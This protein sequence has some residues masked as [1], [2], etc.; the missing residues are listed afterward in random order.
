[1]LH[2][3]TNNKQIMSIFNIDPLSSPEK[4]SSNFFTSITTFVGRIIGSGS[5][6]SSSELEKAKTIEQI[7][8]IVEEIAYQALVDAV[9]E[10]NITSDRITAAES[11]ILLLRI[12]QAAHREMYKKDGYIAK[13]A[14]LLDPSQVKHV[15]DNVGKIVHDRDTKL[16]NARYYSLSELL[17][18]LDDH[19]TMVKTILL[20]SWFKCSC[21][22]DEKHHH[23]DR[24]KGNIQFYEQM[25]KQLTYDIKKHLIE[26]KE[27]W[28]RFFPGVRQAETDKASTAFTTTIE[29]RQYFTSKV[30]KKG[31]EFSSALKTYSATKKTLDTP[32]ASML[33][34]EDRIAIF[35]SR[36]ARNIVR[37]QDIQMPALLENQEITIREFFAQ[38]FPEKF[39]EN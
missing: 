30:N 8:T 39:L 9:K 18:G 15:I 31:L 11:G 24:V 21:F 3:I 25:D 32:L 29:L 20:R 5:S 13:R 37:S 22:S 2:K 14:T 10:L 4:N 12:K 26:K 35:G 27:F 38:Y 16:T 1:M 28:D 34:D 19:N 33:T 6:C 17:M 36:S 7:H 23:L